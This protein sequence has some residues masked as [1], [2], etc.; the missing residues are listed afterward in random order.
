MTLDGCSSFWSRVSTNLAL[1]KR[2]APTK[3]VSASIY[4]RSSP[5][6][7]WPYLPSSI[8]RLLELEN[9]KNF[10]KNFLWSSIWLVV[11]LSSLNIL[12]VMLERRNFLYF[13]L[14][15]TTILMRLPLLRLPRPVRGRISS[16]SWPKYPLWYYIVRIKG[17]LRGQ[18]IEIWSVWCLVATL[19][20]T[21]RLNVKAIKVGAL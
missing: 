14:S 19:Q 1:E 17:G 20:R 5:W 4:C 10:E 16:F 8:S 12:E 7:A 2:S 18:G 21:G 3:S 9:I 15:P 11:Q 6:L 13:W